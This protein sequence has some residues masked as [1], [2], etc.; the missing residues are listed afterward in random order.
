M[1]RSYNNLGIYLPAYP[2]VYKKVHTLLP[3]RKAEVHYNM[4][5]SAN[6]KL[7]VVC[8]PLQ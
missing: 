3:I 2:Q 7:Y 1:Q 8:M 5:R 4:P 6:E